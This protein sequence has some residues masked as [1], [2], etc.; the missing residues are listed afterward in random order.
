M[1]Q[2]WFWGPL[3]WL[4]RKMGGMP[5]YRQQSQSTTDLL[6]QM[7]RE[8][9]HFVVAITPEGTR[10]VVSKWK[11][12][13]YYAAL[14]A[15]IPIQCYALDYAKKQIIGTL[16]IHPSGDLNADMCRI[17]DYYRSVNAKHPLQFQTE[18]ILS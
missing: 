11:H 1:K 6:A 8:S 18:E 17:M 4:F 14:K 5:V 7:A 15:N 2:E 16:E 13:F 9:D 3:G 12:G 10:K